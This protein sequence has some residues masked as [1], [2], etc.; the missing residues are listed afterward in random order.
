[1]SLVLAIEPDSSQADLLR[2]IVRERAGAELVLVTSSYAATVAMNHQIP[3]LVLFGRSVSSRQQDSVIAHLWS[4]TDS[5]S[6]QTLVIP[7]LKK[8]EPAKSGFFGF[9]RKQAAAPPAGDPAVF[10]EQ[11]VACLAVAETSR[12]RLAQE[13]RAAAE[14]DAAAFERV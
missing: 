13:P 6:V 3:N 11:V 8:A 1:M 14:P 5:S 7:L 2:Q 12:E 4:L 10:T 9:G